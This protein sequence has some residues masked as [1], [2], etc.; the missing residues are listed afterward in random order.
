MDSK[1][2]IIV[3]LT[4]V[5]VGCYVAALFGWQAAP[6]DKIVTSVTPIISVIIGY[7][8]GRLPSEKTEDSL[9]KQ[10]DKK[11]EEADAARN[12]QRDAEL[13][14]ADLARKIRDAVAALSASAPKAAVNEL[15]LTLS[16]GGT[17]VAQPDTIRNATVAALKILQS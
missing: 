14:G 10:V 16:G 1:T 13:H 8:F 17:E 3:I 7:Y 6:N 11:S 12:A 15:A 5:F 4:I 9:K 2:W